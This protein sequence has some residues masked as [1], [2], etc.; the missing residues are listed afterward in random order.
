MCSL[1]DTTAFPIVLVG[2]GFIQ[3]LVL[4]VIFCPFVLFLLATVLSVFLRFTNSDYLTLV[5]SNPSWISYCNPL[6]PRTF[7][8]PILGLRAYLM[9]SIPETFRAHSF[10]YLR[11][12]SPWC[13]NLCGYHV[14][15]VPYSLAKKKCIKIR[16]KM[17]D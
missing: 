5:S 8:F 9:N 10:R 2:F 17:I 1:S 16:Q 11:C 6:V 4:C 14:S 13:N 12:Y 3:F 15:T 7:I